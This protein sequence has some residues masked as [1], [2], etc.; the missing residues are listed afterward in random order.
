M[1]KQEK[2]TADRLNRKLND[3]SDVLEGVLLPE[4]KVVL[5]YMVLCGEKRMS[6]MALRERIN[7]PLGEIEE[8]FRCLKT[9]QINKS[10][11]TDYVEIE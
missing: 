6:M 8:A 1:S 2:E 3:I 4:A 7:A 5:A 9:A 10:K 11:S